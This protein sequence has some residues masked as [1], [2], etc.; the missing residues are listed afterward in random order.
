[1]MIFYR[2]LLLGGRRGHVA[3]YDCQTMSIGTELQLQQ[4]VFDVQYL[5]NE[6]LFAVAQQKYAYIYDSKGVEI[7]CL[8]NHERPIKLDYLPYHFLLVTGAH[9]GWIKWQDISVGEYVAGYQT[10]HGP[11]RAMKQNPFNAVMHVGHSNG[12]V[13][14]WSPSAGKSLVSMFCHKAAITDVAIDREGHYMATTALDG[15][16]KVWDL[17]KLSPIHTYKLNKPGTTLD[18]SERGMI[19]VGL[20]RHVQI[21]KNAFTN[22]MDITY[23]EHEIRTP[24][25]ALS[26]GGGAVA[27]TKALLS[28]VAVNNIAFRPLEDLLCIG[29]SHGISSM[30]VPGSGE[31]N[32]DS[33]ENNPFATLKQR[34]E[35]EV[36]NLLNKLQPE[37]I[38]LGNNF[39]HFIIH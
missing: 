15:F 16:L 37:M 11:I 1:M 13:S 36:Q 10:G 19:G 5:H 30:I 22:P 9:S 33:F 35:A 8:K 28:R 20:G 27:A 7:H 6:T 39:I 32:F 18:I 12:V 24:N 34:R 14:L 38:G 26:S 25:V 29:H 23:L 31:P 21:L 17:R 4:E 3:T 2:H